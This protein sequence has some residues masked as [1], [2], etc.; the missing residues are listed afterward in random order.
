MDIHLLENADPRGLRA[1]GVLCTWPSGTRKVIS[2]VHQAP[3]VGPNALALAKRCAAAALQSCLD[4]RRID[5]A[6]RTNWAS[7]TAAIAAHVQAWSAR[8]GV[9]QVADIKPEG[10]DAKRGRAVLML[11]AAL[12]TAQLALDELEG[13]ARGEEAPNP[14]EGVTRSGAPSHQTASRVSEIPGSMQ[15]TAS[16]VS[17]IPTNGQETANTPSFEQAK[18]DLL[19][20]FAEK[21]PEIPQVQAD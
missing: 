13:V 1:G 21:N 11:G 2:W 12:G 8:L 20:N 5:D 7:A 14:E 19:K 6:E 15:G 9:A 4:E 17:E 18:L 3:I 16:Q 10:A